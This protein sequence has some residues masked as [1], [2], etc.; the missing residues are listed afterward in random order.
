MNVF[1]DVGANRGQTLKAVKSLPFD[2]I[3]CFEPASPCWRD[4]ERL[5]HKATTI[6]RFGLSDH[7]TFVDELCTFR[8]AS[9]WFRANV[10]NIDSVYMKLSCD[11]CECDI[12]CDLMK[13]CELRKVMHV[14]IDVDARDKSAVADKLAAI[15][16][17]LSRWHAAPQVLT[18]R[19]AMVGRSNRPVKAPLLSA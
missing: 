3:Y 6:E 14:M 7:D 5:A 10:R 12:M 1:L 19:E 15:K 17:S 13:T 18:S 2:R 4:L 16:K 8:K 9:D 11:G